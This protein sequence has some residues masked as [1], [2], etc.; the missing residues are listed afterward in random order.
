MPNGGTD[1]C[2]NCR[3][4]RANHRAANIKSA[5][6]H[7]RQAFCSVHQIPIRDRAWTYCSNINATSPDL[8][9]PINSVGLHANGYR[10]I[11]W[12]G[13]SQPQKAESIT[14]CDICGASGS[15]GIEINLETLNCHVEFCSNEHYCEWYEHQSNLLDFEQMYAVGRNEL[16]QAVLCSDV[17]IITG[18]DVASDAANQPDYFGWTP[19]HLAAFL[20]FDCG[21]AAL[22]KIGADAKCQDLVGRLPIDLAGAE[23]H[24]KIVTKLESISYSTE[25][26]KE[27]ALLQAASL[28]NLELVEALV[29]DGVRIECKDY[30]GRTPL[31]VAVWGGHYTTTVFLL[32]SGANIHVIDE[33]GNTPLKV[34]DTWRTGIPDEL[35]RLI[36]EWAKAS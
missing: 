4:N 32:D 28:G 26:D 31:L 33:Y 34:V 13:R 7:T 19:L 21:V 24:G 16:H 18:S 12:L 8:T 15:E 11:P 25:G 2:M 20:G 5:P 1:N 10:R 3:H 36:H 14:G 27:A 9:V 17:E 6:S 29:N 35:H 30:R 23:G 22:I